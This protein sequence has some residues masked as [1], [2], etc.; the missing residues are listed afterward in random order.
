MR[1]RSIVVPALAATLVLSGP[2]LGYAIGSRP[3]AKAKAHHVYRLD[4]VVAVHEPG[5]PDV[6]SSHTMNVEEDNSSD[7]RAGAN[8]PLVIGAGPGAMSAP[9]QDVGLSLHC[10]LTRVGEDVLIQQSTELTGP[11]GASEPGPRALHKVSMHGEV[12]AAMG[13]PTVVASVEE[14]VSH[15]RYEVT[16]TA[17]KLR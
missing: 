3:A 5:R 4:Y 12:V 11:D 13:K 16:V 10:N 9:R 2:V 8:I 17:S 7:L 6:T 1:I 15:A 14:P